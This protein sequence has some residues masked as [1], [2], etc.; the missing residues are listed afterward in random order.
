[1][2][3]LLSSVGLWFLILSAVALVVV[4]VAAAFENGAASCVAVLV[5]AVV[6]FWMGLVTME[7]IRDHPL[8]I[9]VGVAGYILSGVVWMFVKWYWKV[10]SL[11][12]LYQK[13]RDEYTKAEPKLV[14]QAWEN[15]VGYGRG[16]IPPEIGQW[17]AEALY[18]L[19]YWPFSLI[20]TLF[21]DFFKEIFTGIYNACTRQLQ[22]VS[23]HMFKD[24]V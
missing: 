8:Q 1:M 10:R 11:R 24:V 20:T 6:L 16:A 18:W 19:A 21:T 9:V 7:W 3:L 15:R 12:A 4:L 2:E 23:D 17:K 5:Y 13:L 22:K 14:Q